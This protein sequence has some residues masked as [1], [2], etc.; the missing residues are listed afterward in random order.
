ML[1]ASLLLLLSLSDHPFCGTSEANTARVQMLHARG[2]RGI[3]TH[4]EAQPAS[5]LR[6]GT[7]YV[8]ADARTA[9]GGHLNDLGGQSLVLEPRGGNKFAVT[10]TALRYVPT[11]AA[12]L[13][14]FSETPNDLTL[15]YDLEAF[16]FPLFG[17]NVT[18]LYITAYNGIHAAPPVISAAAQFDGLE[19]AVQRGAMLSP[20]AFTSRSPRNLAYPD[21]FVAE[22]DDALVL[23]WRSSTGKY[24]GYDVQAEL[25]KDGT[26]V[27]S[28]RSLRAVEWGTP[29]ATPGLEQ[30]KPAERILATTDD[31]V[32]DTPVGAAGIGAMLDVGRVEVTRLGETELLRVR[33]KLNLAI[34]TEQIEAGKPLLYRAYLGAGL[35]EVRVERGGSTVVYTTPRPTTER[36]GAIARVNGDTID[37]FLAQPYLLLPANG[38]AQLQILTALGNSGIDV[39]TATVVIDKPAQTIA[40]DLSATN[41]TLLSAP[42]AEAFVLPEFDPYAVWEQV[43]AQHGVPDDQV[44]GVAF[45]QTFYSDMIFYAGAY[46]TVGNSQAQGIGV[47]SAA[48]GPSNAKTPA[49]LHMSHYT[50]GYNSA[51]KSTSQVLLHEFGH[52]W[53]YFATIRENGAASRILNP[54]S[55]HPA[56]YVHMPAAFKVYDDDESSTMGGAFYTQQGDGRWK[57]RVRNAGYTWMELYLMGLASRDEVAP[58]FYLNNTTPKLDG[59]YWPDDNTVVSG[60]RR[61]VSIDQLV[62]ANGLRTPGPAT[63]QRNF[64]VLFVL[65]TRPGEAPTAEHIAQ[66]N[67]IRTMFERN[68]HLATGGRGWMSTSWTTPAK[69]RSVR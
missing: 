15:K 2:Q 18:T 47:Y 16:A 33:M 6:D 14:K 25:R 65:V 55:A 51:E 9:S 59:E 26:I 37:L 27:Y 45:Y 67:S 54:V 10:R 19:A 52:R 66:M 8:E 28:Y 58:W 24:F 46:S 48:G 17:Q 34:D 53:L 13:H 56:E 44:D 29:V 31:V 32:G 40:N 7:F 68:F 50:Y 42:I 30:W 57:A 64:K 38:R 35:A 1:S 22:T 11:P 43:Q 62:A 61:E 60:E 3:T 63:S 20:L 69:R 41:A 4:A 23:T 49:L 39:H 12:P 5:L 36:N 21:L